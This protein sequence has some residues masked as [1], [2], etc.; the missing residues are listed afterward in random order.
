M[1][2]LDPELR[3]RKC[4]NNILCYAIDK[5]RM[6]VV[7]Q[8]VLHPLEAVVLCLYDGSRSEEEVADLLAEVTRSSRE[9]STNFLVKFLEHS[10]DLLVDGSYGSSGVMH[11]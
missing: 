3:L 9:Q 8:R 7:R 6:D 11:K 5:S 1:L 10:G 2:I 4:E